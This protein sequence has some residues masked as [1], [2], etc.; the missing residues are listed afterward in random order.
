MFHL[1]ERSL[2][3][4][5]PPSLPADLS[6]GFDTFRQLDD[7]ADDHLDSLLK[8]IIDFERQSSTK[9]SADIITW[10]GMI[11]KVSTILHHAHFLSSP[12]SVLYIVSR[13]ETSYHNPYDSAADSGIL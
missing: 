6:R 11:T 9:C 3:Y 8:T 12:R 7:T 5:Y 10:R 4:Y 1:D 2:R 13:E